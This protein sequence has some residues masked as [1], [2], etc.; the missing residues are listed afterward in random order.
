MDC[1]VFARIIPGPGVWISRYR[2]PKDQH[3]AVW[4]SSSHVHSPAN[5]QE[6][7]SI[8]KVVINAILGIKVF[9]QG[10]P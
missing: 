9:N 3:V 1:I 4:G 7:D 10:V 8:S 2:H 5:M 6:L